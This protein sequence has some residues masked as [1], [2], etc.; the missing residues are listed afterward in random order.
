MPA[1]LSGE[2]SPLLGAA[3]NLVR[4][5]IFRG[6]NLN[7]I[8][9]ELELNSIDINTGLLLNMIG[10]VKRIA[11]SADIVHEFPSHI[12]IPPE[13][14]P[15]SDR[16]LI[17]NYLYNFRGKMQDTVTGE[18]YYKHV[19][20]ASDEPISIN[21][22]SDTAFGLLLRGQEKYESLLLDLEPVSIERSA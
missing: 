10:V 4:G 20:V 19:S 8:K 3:Y 17:S 5:A 22:A 12:I 21:T 18:E 16:N 15:V 7:E 6:L 2:L 9:A 13:Q 11:G 1:P 14:I